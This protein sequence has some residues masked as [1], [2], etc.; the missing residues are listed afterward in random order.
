M[1]PSIRDPLQPTPRRQQ[2]KCGDFLCRPSVKKRE[3]SDLLCRPGSRDFVT[4]QRSAHQ[5]QNPRREDRCQGT[6]L[7]K[8]CRQVRSRLLSCRSRETNSSRNLSSPPHGSDPLPMTLHHLANTASV[9]SLQNFVA[10]ASIE[11]AQINSTQRML[12]AISTWSQDPI[13]CDVVCVFDRPM[14]K[15]S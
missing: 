1:L 3:R 14:S 4:T 8:G 12:A 5:T 11:V 9:P 6:N 13:C 7:G 2:C 15:H 10:A